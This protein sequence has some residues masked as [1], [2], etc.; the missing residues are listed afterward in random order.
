M[1]SVT[2]QGNSDERAG[3]FGFTTLLRV[4]GVTQPQDLVWCQKP[5]YLLKYLVWTVHK[6]K[7][8]LLSRNNSRFSMGMASGRR[9]GFPAEHLAGHLLP[10]PT[11]ERCARVPSPEGAVPHFAQPP[12]VCRRQ[13]QSVPWAAKAAPQPSAML[14]DRLRR[15]RAEHPVFCSPFARVHRKALKIQQIV[16]E[17]PIRYLRSCTN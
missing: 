5:I 11:A 16:T 4:D 12:C 10:L 14:Q 1:S 2:A 17:T 7:L 6:P 9:P 8:E 15:H 3:L 13:K